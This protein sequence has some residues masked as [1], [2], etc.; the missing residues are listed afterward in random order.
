MSAPAHPA[1][2]T[3]KFRKPLKSVSNSIQVRQA[4]IGDLA[5]IVPLFDAYRQ[6]Y[7]QSPDLELARSFLE[8]RFHNKESV[9][10]IALAPDGSALGFTQLYPCFSSASARRIF[11]LNDLFVTPEARRRKVG[12]A[13]LTAAADFGRD[14]GALRLALS[15]A[16]DNFSAQALY[17]SADWQRDKVFCTYTLPL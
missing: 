9:I 4:H 5:A 15:T 14:A 6:F 17:E 7:R 2:A 8:E 11:I 3:A 10:F 1:F 16:L 13:L 12:R